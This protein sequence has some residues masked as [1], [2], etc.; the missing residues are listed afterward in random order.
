MD[1]VLFLILLISEM[2]NVQRAKLEAI[3][4]MNNNDDNGW[5]E[6]FYETV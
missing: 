3:P 5:G 4:K 6:H 1:T 2:L